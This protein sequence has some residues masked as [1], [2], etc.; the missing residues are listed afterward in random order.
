MGV[1]RESAQFQDRKSLSEV[2]VDPCSLRAAAA[3]SPT[4]GWCDIGTPRAQPKLAVLSPSHSSEQSLLL[5]NLGALRLAAREGELDC[6]ALGARLLSPWKGKGF[7]ETVGQ[8]GQER[9]ELTV[10]LFALSDAALA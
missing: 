5:R 7:R 1:R 9:A 3:L 8:V 6:A 4:L 10:A 2:P